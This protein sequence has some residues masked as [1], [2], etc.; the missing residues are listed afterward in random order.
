MEVADEIKAHRDRFL[1][2]IVS[3]AERALDEIRTEALK[4]FEN[5]P[6]NRT[7][8][9]VPRAIRYEHDWP[10]GTR[11]R[12][13]LARRACARSRFPSRSPAMESVDTIAGY[14]AWAKTYDTID[15]PLVALT[16]VALRA[17]SPALG[18]ARVLEIGCGTGRNARFFLERGARY[19]GVDGSAGMLE[20]AR[21]RE[22]DATWVEADL[23]ALPEQLL[24]FDL[25]FV[26]L[27]LEHVADLRA[28]FGAAFATARP[29]G[30]LF[31]FE[32]HP[33]Y[34]AGGKRANFRDGDR[35]LFLPS[36]EHRLEDFESA[37]RAASW[38]LARTTSWYATEAT[39]AES[40]KLRRYLG[41][42]VLLELRASRAPNP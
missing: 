37:L 39:C 17:W 42:P 27:V 10:A 31:V 24:G 12:V 40:D 28:A 25:V 13:A 16:R 5:A 21:R 3:L 30:A 33:E 22:P 4:R 2:E 38:E 18:G 35:E 23:L 8:T 34:R 9:P 36:F 26:S 1:G 19:V 11:A 7:P 15:N 14:D 41:Q 32:I 29:G 6:A 20:V